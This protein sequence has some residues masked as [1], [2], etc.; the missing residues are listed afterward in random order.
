VGTA[1]A[2]RV[3]NGASTPSVYFPSA[4]GHY[5]PQPE[6][7][8]FWGT[9]LTA[10][11][12]AAQRAELVRTR[13]L[14]VI[15]PS[16]D[17]YDLR[18]QEVQARKLTVLDP[19]VRPIFYFNT[20]H[21][22]NEALYPKYLHG[23]DV[24]TM[25]LHDAGGRPI[26]F[27]ATRRDP[28]G[29]G[30]YVDETSPAWHA[31][32]VHTADRVLATGHFAGI[33]MDSMRPLTDAT[34]RAAATRL[35]A[36]RIADWNRG[37]QRL[38]QEVHARFPGKTVL[39]NGISQVVPGQIDR[40]LGPLTVADGALNEQFCLE[41]AEPN[42]THIRSDIALMQRE[43][44]QGKDLLEKVNYDLAHALSDAQLASVRKRWGDFCLGA[45]LLGW[46]PGSSYFD[47][48]DGYG[49]DQLDTQPTEL[50]L[51]LGAPTAPATF[52]G[53]VGSRAFQR[54]Q[55]Y[56]NL[57]TASAHVKLAADLARVEDR[58][59]VGQ[60]RA[61]DGLTLGPQQAALLVE[62]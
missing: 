46:T 30:Y 58:R 54:G 39:Y 27:H 62:R 12:T 16:L 24:G 61:G 42:P 9:N 34:D 57:G 45:F 53:D 37:Q 23:F 52:S 43:G 7:T 40:D 18:Q 59:I 51:D 28:Q 17:G 55:V 1:V 36:S 20:K 41:H 31:F 4:A 29:T 14:V 22:L 56:V 3:F 38:L 35:D 32:Y 21:Y 60:F 49:I 19:D 8:F 6:R 47:F 10:T 5:R 13:R 26:R 25:A 50:D 11:F 44:G 15:A 48:S 2:V 33:A